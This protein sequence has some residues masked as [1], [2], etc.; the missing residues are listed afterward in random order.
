LSGFGFDAAI[1]WARFDTRRSLA[2]RSD[3]ELPF[4]DQ[5]QI[6]GPALVLDTCV[7]IDQLQGRT[8]ILLDALVEA[9]QTLHSTIAI[10]EMMH[11]V[12]RLDPR[13][14]RSAP[15]IGAIRG[16]VAAMP[17]HRVHVPDPQVL[18]R[19]GL[20]SGILHRL[21]GHGR[22][23][24]F[25]LLHDCVLFL[26]AQKL[27]CTLLTAHVA[28]FDPMLQLIPSGRVLFYRTRGG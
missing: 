18:G 21:Q 10:Q 4:V 24:R 20:L 14:K 6:G 2:R 13:D 17:S 28:D 1:R 23:A 7:Y 15:A 22:E 27:G 26:Q 12:G 9:R 5:A 16:L 11:S 25:R 3:E 8:P 19:A